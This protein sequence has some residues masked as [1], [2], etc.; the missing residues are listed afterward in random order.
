MDAEILPNAIRELASALIA[1]LGRTEPM[2]RQERSQV[3]A[4][5]I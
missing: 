1:A 5:S 2:H 3:V 4:K